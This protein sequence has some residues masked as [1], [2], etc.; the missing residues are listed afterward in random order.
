MPWLLLDILLLVMEIFEE[1]P[2]D[3]KLNLLCK[4]LLLV[5]SQGVDVS[6]KIDSIIASCSNVL[7]VTSR[8]GTSTK[9]P[10]C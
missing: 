9:R 4:G 7:H 3:E 10:N 1:K 2:V 6:L 5:Q 8:F